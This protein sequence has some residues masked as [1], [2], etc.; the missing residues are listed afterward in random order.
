MTLLGEQHPLNIEQF[1]DKIHERLVNDNAARNEGY[2]KSGLISA[3]KLGQPTLWAVLDILGIN[4]DFNPYLL[5]KFKRGNDVEARAIS[6]L[7]DL[8]IDKI[9][10]IIEGNKNPEWVKVG[11]NAVIKGE[12]YLQYPVHYRG[13]VG[14]VDLAQR[15]NGKIILHEVKSVTKLAYDKVAATG[16]SASSKAKDG[17]VSSN[18]AAP[19]E[20]HALQLSFYGLAENTEQGFLHY[21]NADDYRLTSFAI[22]S[23]EYKEEVDSE[24][25][26]IQRAFDSKVI[27]EFDPFLGYHKA[28]KSSTYPDW[29]KLNRKEIL[30]KLKTEHTDIYNKF[31]ATTL[32]TGEI[33]E[34]SK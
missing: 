24:I 8:P 17:S 28:Y 9:I 23:S 14:Y 25:D 22:N 2:T 5:G 18:Q 34:E 30:D 21:F 1:G 10:K 19:Y 3:S 13:G 27:P 4:K 16:R 29:N 15:N 20:H 11:K 6:F 26:A 32:P 12:V 7:T 31:I 33:N